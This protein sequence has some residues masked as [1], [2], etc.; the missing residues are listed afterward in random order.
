[1]SRIER[2]D[3]AIY[4]ER[5]KAWWDHRD[6]IFR[7]LHS[8]APAR[9]RFFERELPLRLQGAF[10]QG[11]NVV[12]VG[13]GG[14]YM[15]ELM[16][17]QGALVLGVDIAAGA[18]AAASQR[19]REQGFALR[20]HQGSADNLPCADGSMDVAVCTDVLVHVPRPQAVIREIARVL[21]PGGL[22][23]FSSIH[24][25]WISKLVMIT[26]GEDLLGIVH[27]GTHDP[28][29]FIRPEELTAWM[30]E[31]GLTRVALEG[32]GPTGISWRSGMSFGRWP[33]TQ[34]MYQGAALKKG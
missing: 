11:L 21:R 1:M 26:L 25:T 5:Q 4:H 22:F 6:P 13:C 12:D 2:N 28:A 27:K 15:S 18:L 34:V 16:A 31:S 14:G 19:A 17:R 23:L 10:W 24:R 8:L 33:S 29:R 32:I 9:W 7:P 3:L 20:L 30:Q